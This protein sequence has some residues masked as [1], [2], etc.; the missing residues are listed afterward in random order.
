M[1]NSVLIGQY[2]DRDSLLHRLDPRTKIVSLIMMMLSFL[3]LET[4]ISYAVA[5]IIILGILLLSQIPFRFFWKGIRPI[6]VILIFT[7]LYHV[8]FTKGNVIWSWSFI[9]LTEEGLQNGIRF[10]WRIMLFVLLASILTLTTKPL[11]LSQGLEK[12]LSPLSKLHVPIEQF[13]LMIVIA[14]RF[15]P[16]IIEELERILLAQ[17]ARGYDIKTLTLPKRIFAYIPIL[18]PLL[19]TIIQRAEQLTFAIDARAYGNGKGRTSY[20]LL[21]LQRVDYQA[22]GIVMIMSITMLL[23]KVGGI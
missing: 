11:S 1:A 12:L 15:I 5:S 17:K 2:V 8:I 3:T 23:I 16:T 14:I 10:V 9:E 6:L 7:F 21:K 22:G 19:I 18:I 4:F 20:K 13:S